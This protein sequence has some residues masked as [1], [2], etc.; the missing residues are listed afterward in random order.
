MAVEQ[1]WSKGGGATARNGSD[2]R[3]NRTQLR[4]EFVVVRGPWSLLAA[5]VVSLKRSTIA[6]GLA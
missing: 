4:G 1:M 3:T 2:L 5:P 6:K